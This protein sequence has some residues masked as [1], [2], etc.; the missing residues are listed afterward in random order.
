MI[1]LTGNNLKPANETE[2]WHKMYIVNPLTQI[3]IN[4]IHNPLSQ[5]LHG[6]N[7]QVRTLTDKTT[8]PD[9]TKDAISMF[10]KPWSRS[11][12]ITS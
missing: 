12:L 5:F 4:E 10:D 9:C 7:Q 11:D 1:K 8:S 6:L 2:S 3:H